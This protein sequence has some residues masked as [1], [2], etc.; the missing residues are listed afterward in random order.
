MQS[1]RVNV[2]Y[3]SCHLNN[4][5]LLYVYVSRQ[6]LISVFFLNGINQFYG[7]QIYYD[8]K[9]ILMLVVNAS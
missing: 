8:W 4:K 1:S 6:S 5:F 9:T 2:P 3:L 7:Q